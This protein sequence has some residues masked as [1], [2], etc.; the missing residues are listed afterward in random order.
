[1]FCSRSDSVK[2]RPGGD[3]LLKRVKSTLMGGIGSGVGVVDKHISG[4]TSG[5]PILD[6]K[7]ITPQMW[8]LFLIFVVVVSSMCK[9]EY[10]KKRPAADAT[11]YYY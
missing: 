4:A 10:D 8:F 9:C 3:T 11:S 5:A 7:K 1:M 6:L 2:I